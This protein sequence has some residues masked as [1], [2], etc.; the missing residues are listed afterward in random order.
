MLIVLSMTLTGCMQNVT[1]F[2]M[3]EWNTGGFDRENNYILR[4]KCLLK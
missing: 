2:T 4:N 1:H 3:T